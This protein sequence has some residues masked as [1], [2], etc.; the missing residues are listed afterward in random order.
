MSEKYIRE[1]SRYNFLVIMNDKALL[2]NICSNYKQPAEALTISEP[3]KNM[4]IQGPLK[5]PQLGEKAKT[6]VHNLLPLL[7]TYGQFTVGLYLLLLS[8]FLRIN[9]SD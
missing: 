6:Q 1:G 5:G 2:K 4:K 7:F 9:Q 8:F 3:R